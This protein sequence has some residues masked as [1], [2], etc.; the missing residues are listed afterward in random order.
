MTLACDYAAELGDNARKI[1][2]LYLAP[3]DRPVRANYLANLERSIRHVQVFMSQELP[4]KRTFSLASPVVTIAQSSHEAA[5]FNTVRPGGT[6][7][8]NFYDNARDDAA[9]LIGASSSPNDDWL[10]YVDAEPDCDQN[11]DEA[12]GARRVAG[13][14]DLRGLAGLQTPSQCGS[15]ALVPSEP[16][17]FTG[18]MARALTKSL[19]TD[20]PSYLS[21]PAALASY[22]VSTLDRNV[23]FGVENVA[24]AY[25]DCSVVVTE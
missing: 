2:V 25:C 15:S 1:R 14:T 4:D 16:C 20:Y 8:T 24:A 21:Y 5:W 22:V 13:A 7:S 11:L 18:R 3:S 23:Y 10:I 19:G 12:Y 6:Q 17:I 9:T